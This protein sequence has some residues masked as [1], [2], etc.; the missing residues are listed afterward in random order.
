[1]LLGE[2]TLALE[3]GTPKLVEILVGGLLRGGDVVGDGGVDR[4]ELAAGVLLR[5]DLVG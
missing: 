4:V 2:T 3:D 5:K 1:L